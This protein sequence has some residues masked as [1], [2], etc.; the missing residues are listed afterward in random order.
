MAFFGQEIVPA[1]RKMRDFEWLLESHY[2]YIIMLDTHIS[3]LKS[4]VAYAKQSEKKLLLHA[5]LICGLKGDEYGA[6]FICEEIRPAGIIST[7]S[8]VVTTAKKKGLLAVQRL[9]LLDSLALETSYQ[10]LGKNNPDYIEVLPGI[11]P[12][13][14]KEVYDK[15]RIPIFAG[16][17]I[18]TSEDVQAALDGGALAATSS[19]KHLWK[20]FQPTP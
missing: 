10:I 7:R 15:T 1:V 2:E 12:N 16:G 19:A 20:Q 6:Q 5:D 18:R 17:L 4:I 8:S 9:F 14:I 3:Q 13:I 11:M